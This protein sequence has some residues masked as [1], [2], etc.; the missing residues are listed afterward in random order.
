M[1]RE[2]VHGGLALYRNRSGLVMCG[3]ASVRLGWG[4]PVRVLVGAGATLQAFKGQL[5][6]IED[7]LIS[8]LTVNQFRLGISR[9]FGFGD[10]CNWSSGTH[11]HLRR[12]V[13]DDQRMH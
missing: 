4:W 13:A 9:G 11:S 3:M 5:P 8:A 6:S 10:S 2:Q 12:C 7:A 1:D